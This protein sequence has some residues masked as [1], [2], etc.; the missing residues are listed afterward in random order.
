M[1]FSEVILEGNNR[2]FDFLD[3]SG[4]RE[5]NSIYPKIVFSCSQWPKLVC[6]CTKRDQYPCI[7]CTFYLDI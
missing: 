7:R 2:D 6:L 5:K 1:I 3:E 4:E